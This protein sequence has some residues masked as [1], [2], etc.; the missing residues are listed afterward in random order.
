[1]SIEKK[2]TGL[3]IYCV[4]VVMLIFAL[5]AINPLISWNE[6]MAVSVEEMESS[7]EELKERCENMKLEIEMLRGVSDE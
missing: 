1:M 3:F 4:V 6:R 2:E 7:L 5:V